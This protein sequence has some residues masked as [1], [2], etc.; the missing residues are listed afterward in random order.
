[1]KRIDEFSLKEV[2]CIR[3]KAQIRGSAL[4]LQ[5]TLPWDVGSPKITEDSQLTSIDRI[6]PHSR[7]I[8]VHMFLLKNT[9]F[10]L[11]WRTCVYQTVVFD[12]QRALFRQRN[13]LDRGIVTSPRGQW[14]TRS[15]F[16]VLCRVIQSIDIGD[17]RVQVNRSITSPVWRSM[18]RKA[19]VRRQAGKLRARK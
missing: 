15:I 19:P 4:Y 7:N 16:R 2:R 6:L 13:L 8:N 14:S 1:M 5:I 3:L 17:G 10:S 9:F 18:H 11:I 12:R